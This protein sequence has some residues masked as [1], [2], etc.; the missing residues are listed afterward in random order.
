M[1]EKCTSQCVCERE[2]YLKVILRK[3]VASGVWEREKYPK[4]ILR[5][6]VAS[7]VCV[8]EKY[9]LVVLIEKVFSCVCELDKYLWV[10]MYVRE[11]STPGCVSEKYLELR[12]A[13]EVDLWP[14]SLV[15]EG[16]VG[17]RHPGHVRVLPVRLQPTNHVVTTCSCDMP[18]TKTCKE[19]FAQ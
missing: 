7:G 11:K 13:A 16:G 19:C 10:F 6:G 1:S 15:E 4:V 12:V 5:K 9:L 2:R 18:G 17:H 3:G 8:R 14:L